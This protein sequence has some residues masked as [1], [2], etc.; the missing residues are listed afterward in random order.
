MDR[1]LIEI[2]QF[3]VILLIIRQ[4]LPKVLK[5]ERDLNPDKKPFYRQIE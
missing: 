3:I 4:A 1:Q 2:L 5:I